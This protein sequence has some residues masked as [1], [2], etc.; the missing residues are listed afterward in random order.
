MWGQCLSGVGPWLLPGIVKGRA[1]SMQYGS[2]ETSQPHLLHSGMS[3]FQSRCHGNPSAGFSSAALLCASGFLSPAPGKQ[4]RCLHGPVLEA[5]SSQSPFLP[6]MPG[7]PRSQSTTPSHSPFRPFLAAAFSP[8]ANHRV[9]YYY[10]NLTC[11]RVQ[12][13]SRHLPLCHSCPHAPPSMTGFRSQPPV[14][15][16]GIQTVW[17]EQEGQKERGL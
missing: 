6:H 8:Y 4:D 1:C 10:T 17:V 12:E 2:R 3:T 11:K 13:D 5:E 15:P 7:V 16:A 14:E 9:T